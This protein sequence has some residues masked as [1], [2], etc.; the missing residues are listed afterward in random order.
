MIIAAP[1]GITT[2][3]KRAVINS[4]ERAGARE[5]RLI[6][7]PMAAALGAGLPIG[8]PR[9]SM[10]VDIGG[11]TAEI[12][13]LSLNDIV[14]SSSLRA[15]G[16]AMDQALARHMK[17]V[18]NLEIGDQMAERIKLEIGSAYPLEEELEKEVCG[19][20][21]LAGLPRTVTICGTEVREALRDP[22]DQ[23]LKAIVATLEK[24]PPD[25][26]ADLVRC[27]ITLV[28]GGSLLRGLDRLVAR[29]TGLPVRR[30]DDPATAVA[31]GACLVLDQLESYWP[32]LENGQ[33]G[34]M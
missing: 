16:D 5:V 30:A 12:A 25:L 27:G 14:A 23:I 33:D 24:T 7:E 28:G 11:G 13:V 6:K 32:G 22:L 18:Y 31:R 21:S 17:Q 15:A 20:D 3:E 9:G 10:V 1:S 2:V 29:E 19:R 8:E 34:G 26:C 4:A